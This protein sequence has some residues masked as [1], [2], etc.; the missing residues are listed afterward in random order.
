MACRVPGENN[1]PEQLW[2]SLLDKKD[3]SGEIP[4]LRWE[5]YHRRDPRN[6]DILRQI[7]SRGYYIPDLDKFDSQFFG[8]SP[9]EAEQMDPQQ[10]L[11]L[12]VTWEALESAGIRAKSL[13]GSDTAVFWGT[14][15]DDYSKLLLE[16]LPNIE[17]WMGIGTAYCGIPNRISY[18]LNLK[19]PS[20]AVDAAC[21]SSLVAVHHGEQSILNGESKV[22]IVGGGNAICS[23]NLTRVLQ[24]AG[25]ISSDGRCRSF[26]DEACGYGRGEGAVA[27][28]LKSLRHA[29][30]DG[31]HIQAVVKGTAVAQDGKT[32]GIMAPNAASQELVAQKALNMSGI[33]SRMVHFVEAHATSTAVGDPTEISALSNVYGKYRTPDNPCFIGSI[34]PNIGHLEAGAG[35]MGF[36]KAVLALRKGI[37]PPQANLTTPNT[38]VDWAKS[39]LKIVHETSPWPESRDSR[40]AAICSYGYGGTVS[41]AVIEEFC[42]PS[43]V[44]FSVVDKIELRSDDQ[45]LL[46]ISAPHRSRLAVQARTLKHWLRSEGGKQEDLRSIAKTLAVRRDHHAY[47]A[48]LVVDSHESAVDALESLEMESNHPW[49]AQNMVLGPETR[50]DVVWVFSGHGAQWTDMGKELVHNVIFLDAVNPLNDIVEAEIGV[51]PIHMLETGAFDGSDEIQILTYLIQIGISAVLDHRGVFPHAIIG[52]SVGEVAASAIAGA[53]TREEGTRIVTRRAR[54][55]RKAMG[56]GAMLLVNKPYVQIEEELAGGTDIVA[57]IDSSPSTCVISGAKDAIKQA[58]DNLEARGV[59]VFPVKTDIAFHSPS[60]GFLG[61]PLIGE[62]ADLAPAAPV[63]PLYSTSRLDPRSQLLRGPQYWV[64]NTL[65]PVRLTSAIDAAIADGYRIFLEISSHPLLSHSFSD[66]LA[67]A[68]IEESAVIPTL[69]RNKPSE[70]QIMLAIAQLHCCGANVKWTA[71]LPG[72]WASG[73][74]TT[75]WIHQPVLRQVET[76]ILGTGLTHDPEKHT[77]VGRPIQVAGTDTTVFTTHLDNK[78]KP[79]PGS[80]PLHGTEIIPAACL[81]NTFFQATGANSIRSVV[82]RSPVAINAPRSVQVILEPREIRIMSRLIPGD[83]SSADEDCSSWVTHT[84]AQWVGDSVQPSAQPPTAVDIVAVRARIRSRLSNSFTVDYLNKVGVSSMGFPWAVKEH[85]GNNREMV[86]RVDSAEHMNADDELPWDPSSWASILDA[87]TSVG[88]TL[89]F[90]EP[91]LRMPAEIESV[92]IFSRDR[93]PRKAWLY[94]EKASDSELTSHVA[95]CD[96][97]GA[98]LARFTSMRF[99]EI[100]GTPGANGS[101]ESLVHQI[102][103]P[104]VAPAEEPLPISRVVLLSNNRSLREAYASTL[105][106]DTGRV[107]VDSVAALATYASQSSSQTLKES[108]AIVYIPDSVENITEIAAAV[109]QMTWELLEA[110]KLLVNRNIRSK[111]FVLTLQTGEAETPAAL[112]HSSLLGLSRVLSNEHPDQFGGMIDTEEVI[113]PFHVCRYIRGADVVRIRDGVARTARLRRLPQERLRHAPTQQGSPLLPRANGTYLLTGGVG[114]LGLAV[115]EFL[116]ENGA[117]R[118]VLISRRSLPPRKTWDSVV[119]EDNNS[120]HTIIG[121]FKA[122]E[123]R[124]ATVH[125]ISLDITGYGAAEHLT[126]ALNNLSLPKV[127]GVIHAAGALEDQAVLETTRDAFA[128]VLAPKVRG[129][130]LLH[131]LFPPGSVDFFVLFSSCG[132]LLGFPGQSSYGSG[133]AFLDQ[134]AIHRWQRGDNAVAFQWTAWRGM[135]MGA[136]TDFIAAELESRGITDITADEAF[137]AWRHLAKYN[138]N[139]GVVLRSRVLE[140]DDPLPHPILKDIAMRRARATNTNNGAVAGAVKPNIPNSGPE[141]KVYLNTKVRGCVAHVLHLSDGDIDSKKALS[142]YGVDSVMMASVRRELQATLKVSVPPTLTWSHPTVGHLVDWFAERVGK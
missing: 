40:R 89:F 16:D 80:H 77:L 25:A 137:R 97:T 5:P 12:E 90:E 41:H 79:F 18:H 78:S 62:L 124:G 65:S 47:R 82:L 46:L 113:F 38:Q 117:R 48:A 109:K 29:L 59:K 75:T 8:I 27:I 9:K 44:G 141:L 140:E 112:A 138:V 1:S 114:A 45:L 11:A 110:V 13:S 86:A 74:P 125:A 72:P 7:P 105:P 131:E 100:E 10:F 85:H 93:A 127:L 3:A 121:K 31:D 87:A 57:A 67:N 19:G 35:G 91:C 58:T 103:W 21:A 98:V 23:P 102:T 26:D 96:D 123:D 126:T 52:H 132:H 130:L 32:N 24:K 95:I 94:V 64:D 17:A 106:K 60:L 70:K 119:P 81:L 2:Q 61:E 108:T 33:D 139:H 34:K 54:L 101:V 37:L 99:S 84:T 56:Q 20:T 128:R 122:L 68:K 133:N 104:P 111:L 63:I 129:A 83:G 71:Q 15:S 66:T 136:S 120:T 107:I 43:P 134:L 135:G 53:I 30:N 14:N 92:E 39:G 115:A 88:S 22:A 50:K 28:V 116:V 69:V 36:L 55:Y 42:S 142:D 4:P 73:V 49:L 118:L 6:P 51:S 76:G